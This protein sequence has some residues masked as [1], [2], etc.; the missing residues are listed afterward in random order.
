M[1]IGMRNI[2]PISVADALEELN[3]VGLGRTTS[4]MWVGLTCRDWMSLIQS[5]SSICNAGVIGTQLEEC[6]TASK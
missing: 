6:N 1:D 4:I 5:E 2:L 3:Q